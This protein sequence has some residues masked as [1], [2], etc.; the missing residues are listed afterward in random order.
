MSDVVMKRSDML[1]NWFERG[2]TFFT[3]SHKRGLK[4]LRP[5]RATGKEV[6]DKSPCHPLN[7]PTELRNLFTIE[8]CAKYQ[9]KLQFVYF[10]TE[11]ISPKVITSTK[12]PLRPLRPFGEKGSRLLKRSKV[13]PKPTSRSI[14]GKSRGDHATIHFNIC[15]CA[16]NQSPS[17][18]QCKPII[19]M[20]RVR[21]T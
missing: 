14:S 3:L 20:K 13:D 10:L 16:C 19:I 1:L 15:A 12:T 2:R 9:I 6:R 4:S 11:L 18:L 17:C 8:A 7:C 21:I 5:I